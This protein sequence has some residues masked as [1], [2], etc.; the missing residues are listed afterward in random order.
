M[1]L[2]L[3]SAGIMNKKIEA[4]FSELLNK[5]YNEANLVFITTASSALSGDKSWLIKDLEILN[6]M[7]FRSIDIL[8][9]SA[10]SRDN[11]LPRL[12][13]SDVI[14][15]EGGDTFYL[16]EWIEKSGLKDIFSELIIDKVYVGVS[17]GSCIFAKNLA[18]KASQEMYGDG[19]GR[20]EDIVGL[21]LLPFYIFPHFNNQTY[22]KNVTKENLEKWR[23]EYE[24]DMYLID[25]M[26]AV[27]VN[28]SDIQIVSEGN[29]FKI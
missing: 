22:F 21:D 28:G 5:S 25:D 19:E 9:I 13:S 17:A 7:G 8:D 10:V 20:T 29:Y 2:L 6:K 24:G 15:V 11:W 14:F 12:E 26:S 23:S 16:M 3:T 4:C 1:K 27:C 18:L